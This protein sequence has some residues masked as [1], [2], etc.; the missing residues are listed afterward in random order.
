M[1]ETENQRE[2]SS[3]N[4]TTHKVRGSEEHPSRAQILSCE[5]LKSEST[6]IHLEGPEQM[7]SLDRKSTSP[8]TMHHGTAFPYSQLLLQ[9]FLSL[10]LA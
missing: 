10:C 2:D 4:N 6:P 5:N 1:N 7:N 8:S 9:E 3:K